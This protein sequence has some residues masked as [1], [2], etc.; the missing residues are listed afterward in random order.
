MFDVILSSAAEKF[1]ADA[2]PSL[3]RKLSRCFGNLETDP[4]RGNNV[5]RLTG[6]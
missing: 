4:R 3:S 5:K 1:F 2:D 6:D